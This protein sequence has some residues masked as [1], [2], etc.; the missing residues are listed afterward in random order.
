MSI[1][2]SG[3]VKGAKRAGKMGGYGGGDTAGAWK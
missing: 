1:V 3:T 2:S